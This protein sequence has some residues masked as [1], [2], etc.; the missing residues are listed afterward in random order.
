MLSSIKGKMNR[1]KRN[2]KNMIQW[3][4]AVDFFLLVDIVSLE[5]DSLF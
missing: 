2:Y 3:D 1:M 5:G 4:N